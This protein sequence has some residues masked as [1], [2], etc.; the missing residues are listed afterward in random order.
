[1][2]RAAKNGLPESHIFVP[3]SLL[4]T[5]ILPE[6]LLSQHRQPSKA[7][8]MKALR[9]TLPLLILL[10][11]LPQNLEAESLAE[12][13]RRERSRRAQL[14]AA[15]V[16]YTNELLHSYASRSVPPSSDRVEPGG[17]PRRPSRSADPSGT[18]RE[19]RGW[20]RR[21]LQVKARLAA[22]EQHHEAL[23]AKLDG[24]G[25]GLITKR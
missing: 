22:A 1:M 12:V 16:I 7:Y 14:P 18:T 6:M 23:R 11:A 19:E 8:A 2:T 9:R 20:S 10:G 13:A 21:F 5:N 3:P 15:A 17:S 24:L 25:S 4:P